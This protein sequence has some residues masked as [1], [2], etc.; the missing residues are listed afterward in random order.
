M[1][2]SSASEKPPQRVPLAP[3]NPFMTSLDASERQPADL[4]DDHLQVLAQDWRRRALQG[5]AFARGRAHE[6]EVELRR[7]RLRAGASTAAV[8]RL[9]PVPTLCEVPDRW[10]RWRDV[11]GWGR[12]SDFV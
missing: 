8:E 4:P 2:A 11:D 10:R 5:E 12:R 1:G 9:S 6:F 7:R 3:H